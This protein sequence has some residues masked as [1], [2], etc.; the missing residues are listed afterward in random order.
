MRP[1]QLQLGEIQNPPTIVE[2]EEAKEPTSA[3]A[4]AAEITTS[5]ETKSVQE[6]VMMRSRLAAL[7]ATSRMVTSRLSPAKL[8]DEMRR[9]LNR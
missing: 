9:I 5:I 7:P 6:K 1:R 8:A 2:V 3:L 4:P